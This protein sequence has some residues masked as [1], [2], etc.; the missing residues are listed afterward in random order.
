V[1]SLKVRN[2]GKRFGAEVVQLY[3]HDGHS[4]VD[5]P[6]KELKAF[7]RIELGPGKSG[8]VRFTLDKSAFAYWSAEKK[9][10]V[11][12]P[13]T[14]DVLVGSSSADIGVKSSLDLR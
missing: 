3:V 5:R 7:Q 6:V 4:K 2:E 11:A 12:E 13:G 8:E 14:F 1:V 10:W 9:D